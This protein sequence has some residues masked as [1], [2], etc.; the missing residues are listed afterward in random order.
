MCSMEGSLSCNNMY[1]ANVKI[2][3]LLCMGK[4]RFSIS[5]AMLLESDTEPAI[6]TTQPPGPNSKCPSTAAAIPLGVLVGILVIVIAL[7]TIGWTCTCYIMKKRIKEL[8][9]R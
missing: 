3:G 2:T 9:T 7:M 4:K 5:T 8:N 1:E 6:E